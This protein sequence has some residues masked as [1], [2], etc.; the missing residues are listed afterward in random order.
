MGFNFSLDVRTQIRGKIV[1]DS[2]KKKALYSSSNKWMIPN[3]K[4]NQTKPNLKQVLLIR[5]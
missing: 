4:K 1:I 2:F 5:N 3:N